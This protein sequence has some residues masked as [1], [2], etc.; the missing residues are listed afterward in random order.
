MMPDVI[1]EDGTWI[2]DE[3]IW[4]SDTLSQDGLWTEDPDLDLHPMPKPLTF[5]L[6]FKYVQRF[7]KREGENGNQYHYVEY[8]IGATI[9]GSMITWKFTYPKGGVWPV[10]GD[11]Y[12]DSESTEGSY[13]AAGVTQMLNTA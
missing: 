1:E 13:D 3:E 9:D 2:V 12:A 5:K 11:R 10:N 8:E 7:P 4:R 6:A